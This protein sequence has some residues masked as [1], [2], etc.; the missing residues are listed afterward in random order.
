M[1]AST[2][3]HSLLRIL[4]GVVVCML[5]FQS[6]MLSPVTTELTRNTGQYLANA[7]GVSVGVAPTELNQV[8]AALTARERDLEARELAVAEREI[9]VGINDGGSIP[10]ASDARTTF[11]LAAI[12]FIL[13]V[14]I[15][16]NYVLDYLRSREQLMQTGQSTPIASL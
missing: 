4:T 6:G 15:V 9:S 2:T 11:V 5:V 3:Y 14:L 10:L 16:L 8:T 12:L 13:L 7:V 1:M